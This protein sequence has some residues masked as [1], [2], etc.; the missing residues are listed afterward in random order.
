MF[1]PSNGSHQPVPTTEEEAD[2]I[3]SDIRQDSYEYHGR[4]SSNSDT[5]FGGEHHDRHTHEYRR[6]RTSALSS[7]DN[8]RHSMTEL[9]EIGGET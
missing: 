4:L 9:S 2:R 7:F 1:K 5:V 3:Q 6:G 8:P